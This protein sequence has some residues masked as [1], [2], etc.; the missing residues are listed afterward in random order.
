MSV[1]V[2][3]GLSPRKKFLVCCAD[4]AAATQPGTDNEGYGALI[5]VLDG[6]WTMGSE[7]LGSI[8]FCPWCGKKVMGP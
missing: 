8:E 7:D 4:F 1:E 3:V 6:K 2:V 5:W